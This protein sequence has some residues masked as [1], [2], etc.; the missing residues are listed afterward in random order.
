MKDVHKK[1]VYKLRSAKKAELLKQEFRTP[2]SK[3]AFISKINQDIR[4][5]ELQQSEKNNIH[6]KKLDDS[7]EA[8]D[9]MSTEIENITSSYQTCLLNM[10]TM[11]TQY[12]S[13]VQRLAYGRDQDLDARRK[14][15]ELRKTKI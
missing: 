10:E 14:L 11:E 1:V 12:G 7:Y 8:L 3:A 2:R 6:L 13:F 15:S 4:R 9:V 5:K